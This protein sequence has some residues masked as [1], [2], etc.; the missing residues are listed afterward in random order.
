MKAV[1]L[2]RS[3][4]KE[5][6]EFNTQMKEWQELYYP[7]TK[8]AKE[9]EVEEMAETFKM[10]FRGSDGKPKTINMRVGEANTEA[11][12]DDYLAKIRKEE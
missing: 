4:Q 9:D 8:K 6:D 10:L 7:G 3:E 11:E 2:D 5:V 12:V 1:L